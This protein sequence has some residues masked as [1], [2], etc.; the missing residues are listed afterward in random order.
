MRKTAM[1]LTFLR[2]SSLRHDSNHL[3]FGISL[4]WVPLLIPVQE[5]YVIS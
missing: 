3:I 2:H 5:I 4:P 1:N